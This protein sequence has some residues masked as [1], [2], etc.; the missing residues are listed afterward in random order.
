MSSLKLFT[1][2]AAVCVLNQMNAYVIPTEP[3]CIPPQTTTQAPITTTTP[4]ACIAPVTFPPQ[5]TFPPAT[6]QPVTFPPVTVTQAPVTQGYGGL[7]QTF[8]PTIRPANLPDKRVI[9]TNKG[10][11]TAWMELSYDIPGEHVV[12]TG[13]IVSGQAYAFC[14][15]N[16]SDFLLLYWYNP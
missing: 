4:Q 13:Q 3:I 14:K 6:F 11:Y 16:F 9:V 1:L 2:I 5:V 15:D 7:P 10:G 12:Q 8:A